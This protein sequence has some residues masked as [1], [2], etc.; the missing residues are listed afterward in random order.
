MEVMQRMH[1]Q[2][3]KTLMTSINMLKE[4]LAIAKAASKEHRR[5]SQPATH[6]FFFLMK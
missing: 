1:A 4:H 3:V 5:F 6:F 2:K